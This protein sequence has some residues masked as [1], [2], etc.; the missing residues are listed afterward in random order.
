MNR[1]LC[2]LA[3]ALVGCT[4]ASP[5]PVPDPETD[6]S[7]PPSTEPSTMTLTVREVT[8]EGWSGRLVDVTFTN[9]RDRH[10][11]ILPSPRPRPLSEIVAGANPPQP[12]AAINGGFY[13]TS[14]QPMGLVRAG[15]EDLHEVGERGGS[16][17]LFV[18]GGVPRIVHV[19]G[20]TSSD[21]VTE[22]LQSIDRL[23]HAGES[24]VGAGASA[25]RAARSAVAIDGEGTVHLVVAFDER[26]VAVD[27][28]ARIELGREATRTGPTIAEWADLLR[29][30]PEDGG[31]G[32]RDALGL[33]GGFSTSLV[34]KSEA[35]ALTIVPVN[36]TI[37]AVLLTVNDG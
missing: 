35:R 32:A 8:E 20:Y 18:R 16:G 27:E 36:A 28:D 13:D 6:P 33:D 21:G 19:D 10:L 7:P 15:G 26:A 30:Q 25:R 22:G 2:W 14:N 3:V 23:V 29:R 37:N 31:L 5:T 12:F 24:V 34:V 4:P 9:G 11:R 1:A 17:I